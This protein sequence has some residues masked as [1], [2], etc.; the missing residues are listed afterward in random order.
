[1]T[2]TYGGDFAKEAILGRSFF[3]VLEV[4]DLDGV[5]SPIAVFSVELG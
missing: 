2:T 5:S 4:Y 3:P 1:M